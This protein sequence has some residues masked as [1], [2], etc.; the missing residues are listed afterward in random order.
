[1]KPTHLTLAMALLWLVPGAGLLALDAWTGQVHALPFAGRRLPL[2]V[3]FLLFGAFNL[4][5]W[6]VARSAASRPRPAER[7]RPRPRSDA[8]PDPAFRFDDPPSP[9]QSP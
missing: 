9:D 7:R 1:M 4:L 5:R 3:P 6:W 2:A 8:E